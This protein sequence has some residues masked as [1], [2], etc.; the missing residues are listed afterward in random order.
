MT[1]KFVSPLHLFPILD[2]P[3]KQYEL[4]I[5]FNLPFLHNSHV[6]NKLCIPIMLIDAISLQF[7]EFARF[8]R[9][10]QGRLQLTMMS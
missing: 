5:Q 9:D 6:H 2:K 4:H 8:D 10:S 7:T 1:Y 3:I